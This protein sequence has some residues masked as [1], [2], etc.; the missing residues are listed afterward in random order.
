MDCIIVIVVLLICNAFKKKEPNC[1]ERA[2]RYQE[3]KRSEE[4][5][6]Q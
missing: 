4:V 6:R 3:E 1:L 2:A 5:S